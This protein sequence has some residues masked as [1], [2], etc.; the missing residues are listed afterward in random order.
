MSDISPFSE[1]THEQFLFWLDSRH[2]RA[3]LGVN[4]TTASLLFAAES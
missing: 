3:Y 4:I 1:L 2:Q